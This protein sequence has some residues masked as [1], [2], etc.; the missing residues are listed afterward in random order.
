MLLQR[1]AGH[2]GGDALM[3]QLL[4]LTQELLV[5][6]SRGKRW[7]EW[8]CEALARFGSFVLA[9]SSH[10]TLFTCGSATK[11]KERFPSAFN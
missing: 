8:F 5:G 9:T 7:L 1:H 2:N 6:C 10:Q 4:P 11:A 3:P